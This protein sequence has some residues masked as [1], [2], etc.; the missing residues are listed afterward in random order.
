MEA[1]KAGIL[2]SYPL[3]RVLDRSRQLHAR[4][5][6]V[7]PKAVGK[8]LVNP[9]SKA[10][11]QCRRFLV[12]LP[13]RA[14]GALRRTR[15]SS[16]RSRNAAAPLAAS[17][18]RGSGLLRRHL[19]A[20]LARCRLRVCRC[21]STLVKANDGNSQPCFSA[22]EVLPDGLRKLRLQNRQRLRFLP[23]MRHSAAC[24]MLRLRLSLRA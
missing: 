9:L 18:R 3:N 11:V 21:R 24:R 14:A 20:S 19:I 6:R 4:R 13:A 15:R 7:L 10:D 2:A 5:V 16:W 8:H 22:G 23:E 12:L 1:A 17:T